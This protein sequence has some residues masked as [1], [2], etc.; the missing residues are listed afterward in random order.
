[1]ETVSDVEKRM[2]ELTICGGIAEHPTN[3]RTLNISSLCKSDTKIITNLNAF[4]MLE[5]SRQ[6][7]PHYLSE[8]MMA[9]YLCHERIGT[10]KT[11]FIDG[12]S[13][14]IGNCNYS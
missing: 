12:S 10:A 7:G 5:L 9:E 13:Y 2:P 11:I 6:T 1:M 8:H 3:L 4:G 14:K